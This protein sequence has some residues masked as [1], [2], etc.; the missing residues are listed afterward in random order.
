MADAESPVS[1]KALREG[2]S[3]RVRVLELETQS[4]RS[5]QVSHEEICAER[6]EGIHATLGKLESATKTISDAVT[7]IATAQSDAK[8]FAAGQAEAR[9]PNPWAM[10]AVTVGAACLI[11]VLG[12]MGARL[13]D[14]NDA[15]I[16]A[17]E[18]QA[19]PAASSPLN[20]RVP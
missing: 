3:E 6:Y 8:A 15:K 10:R 1:L 12:W 18:R 2:L 17:A 16:A 5:K 7:Q 14:D 4:N 13:V 11:G 19:V 9:R 20:T